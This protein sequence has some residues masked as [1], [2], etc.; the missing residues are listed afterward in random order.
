MVSSRQLFLWS[1]FE[2]VPKFYR[3]AFDRGVLQPDVK[4]RDVL[5]TLYFEGA[6][7]LRDEAANWFLRELRGR[8]DTIL[9]L[10]AR[11]QPCSYGRLVAEYRQDGLGQDE[12]ELIP[13]LKTLSDRY[14]MIESVPPMFAK[15][16]SR[17]T[18]YEITDN[19]LSAWLAAL[20]R[21]VD[22]SRIRPIDEAVGRADV[23]LQ[24]YEVLR[25]SG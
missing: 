21:N 18:R 16:G 7:P 14:Q 24:I 19:F 6:S 11:L 22:L 8:Y 9:K 2:G 25:S 13:Y 23:G 1:L 4:R 12:R 3:D 10:L 20:S 15:K 5:R 17:K